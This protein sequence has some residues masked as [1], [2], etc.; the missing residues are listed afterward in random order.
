[1]GSDQGKE[2][3]LKRGSDIWK[4]SPDL[5]TVLGA[6]ISAADLKKKF[7][8]NEW[9]RNVI[10][11][12]ACARGQKAADV[13]ESFWRRLAGGVIVPVQF[14]FLKE[15]GE[16]KPWRVII[17]GQHRT[18]GLRKMN[19]ELVKAGSAPLE[20]QGNAARL[21]RDKTGIEA[22]VRALAIRTNE[23]IRVPLRPS[24]RAD[25]ALKHSEAGMAIVDIAAC[26]EVLTAGVE[27]KVY[28]KE[29][30]ALIALAECEPEVRDA[31]DAGRLPVARCLGLVTKSAEK[32]LA[33]VAPKEKSAPRV[34]RRTLPGEFAI[35]L[36]AKLPP[37]YEAVG[38]MLKFF[39]G[40]M[41]ALDDH[42]TL[43]ELAEDTG[44]DLK[45]GRV[46]KK[47]E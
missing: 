20:L 1:M 11:A 38:A 45:T 43:R 31:V 32:Q 22:A 46:T 24:D 40:D 26:V 12:I 37:K 10:D 23:N 13:P 47:A 25:L 15:D 36:A 14:V 9:A 39:G 19:A 35:N 7:S 30:Q 29:V 17:A 6:D 4:E 44:I 28:T 34:Q 16:G 42:P 41:T 8:K 21:P 18:I 5:F 3:G 27:E 2:M 33:A